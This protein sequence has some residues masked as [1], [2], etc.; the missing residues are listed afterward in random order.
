MQ[1]MSASLPS[2]RRNL[3]AMPR[4][5]SVEGWVSGASGT[6]PAFGKTNDQRRG[7]TFKKDSRAERIGAL[8]RREHAFEHHTLGVV[9]AN[10]RMRAVKR[11]HLI[12][13]PNAD[14]RVFGTGA[15]SACRHQRREYNAHRNALKRSHDYSPGLE[16]IRSCFRLLKNRAHGHQSKLNAAPDIVD[17][18]PE[19][20][21]RSP[22]RLKVYLFD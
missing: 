10:A 3:I 11:V 19:A 5:R 2:E 1:I 13:Q 20:R 17:I 9:R 4:T 12:D 7:G 21:H 22:R 8:R 14:R 15:G 6:P 18:R 16:R